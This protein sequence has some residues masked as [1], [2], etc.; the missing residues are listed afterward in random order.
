MKNFPRTINAIL[1]KTKESRATICKR[2]GISKT[3]LNDF[4]GGRKDLSFDAVIALVAAFPAYNAR[5][6]LTGVKSQ[7]MI[8]HQKKLDAAKV[9]TLP[10]AIYPSDEV[11]IARIQKF[12]DENNL[13][14]YSSGEDATPNAFAQLSNGDID[15][16]GILNCTQANGNTPAAAA[17]ALASRL[18]SQSIRAYGEPAIITAPD[19]F[20][21]I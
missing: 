3:S 11:V 5:W 10:A 16:N 19:F 7:A 13:E 17:I 9:V 15:V 6:L 4:L 14:L 12:S 2:A 8:D 21:L 20:A 18:S 1:A